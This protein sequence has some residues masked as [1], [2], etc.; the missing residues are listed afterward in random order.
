MRRPVPGIF[1][2]LLLAL[3][4]TPLSAQVPEYQLKAEFLERFTRFIEWPA[5]SRVSDPATPFVIAV[6]GR[7]PF[8][9][10]LDTL[11]ASRKIKGKTVVVR[12]IT[13][14]EQAGDCDLLFI[15]GGEHGRIKEILA[16][17]A[18]KP[19]LTVGDGD[20]FARSG[21]L[22]NFADTVD[23]GGMVAFEISE[24]AVKKSGLTVSSKL[25]RLARRVDGEAR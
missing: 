21:V 12:Q 5:D 23:T 20:E 14:P 4:A 11:S 24:P 6:I 1:L 8:G 22:F 7:N 17:T 25:L 2:L 9:A 10:Y 15:A 3:A 19:I 16:R 13:G 18:G